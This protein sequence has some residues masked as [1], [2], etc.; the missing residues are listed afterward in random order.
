[1]SAALLSPLAVM[2]DDH[3]GERRYYDRDGSTIIIGPPTKI[4]I[5]GRTWWNGTTRM[6]RL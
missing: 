6:F 3:H 1:M 5:T 4:S 2:A